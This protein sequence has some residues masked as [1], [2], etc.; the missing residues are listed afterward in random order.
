MLWRVFTE[1]CRQHSLS[2]LDLSIP[3]LAEFFEHLFS[4]KKLC[5]KT[6]QGYRSCIAR[7]YRLQGSHDPGTDPRLSSLMKSYELA[8]PKVTSLV[9]KWS[10]PKVLRFL[11]SPSFVP[12][13]TATEDA[14]RDKALF[15]LAL[16]TAARVSEL[17]ALSASPDC[18]RWDDDGSVVLITCP[19]FI[20]KNR[21]PS[22]GAQSFTLRPLLSC[23][24]TCPV[25]ALDAYLRRTHARR[26]EQDP[27]FLPKG[28]KKTSPQTVSSWMRA[29]L[30]KAF[31]HTSWT[32]NGPGRPDAA[33][34]LASPQSEVSSATVPFGTEPT[35][36]ASDAFIVQARTYPADPGTTLLQQPRR[37]PV[38]PR[39]RAGAPLD[40]GESRTRKKSSR[41]SQQ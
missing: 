23:P 18:M 27:L 26:T 17:H 37:S 8:R 38:S 28:R 13:E 2:P 39:T 25:R 30:I 4:A 16:A 5:P 11:Q 3:Q 40:S 21:L 6:I 14:L 32:E 19:G 7:V 35:S 15:L 22:W 41:P 24:A 31:A 9:P 1:Y 29:L 34:V 33:D 36:A 20:A 10:L 12:V